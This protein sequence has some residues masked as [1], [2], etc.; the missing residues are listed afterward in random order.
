MEKALR[1]LLISIIHIAMIYRV[2]TVFED[3]RQSNSSI[4]SEN[5]ETR[6]YCN[7]KII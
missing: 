5:E 6:S 4:L 1:S 7:Y 2:R 3:M